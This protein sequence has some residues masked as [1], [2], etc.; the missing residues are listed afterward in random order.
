MALAPKAIEQKLKILIQLSNFTFLGELK[1]LIKDLE[2]TKELSHD[3][4]AAVRG[5]NQIGLNVGG[6]QS[7]GA[8][9]LFASPVT[10]VQGPQLNLN[11]STST[12]VDVASILNSAFAGIGQKA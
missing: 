10:M 8:G 4:R 9:F 12:D 7:V 3:E 11:T 6:P 1:M 2:I 5:G